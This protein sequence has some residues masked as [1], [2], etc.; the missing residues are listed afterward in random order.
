M[1]DVVIFVVYLAMAFPLPHVLRG[2][3]GDWVWREDW[4][5]PF[6]GVDWQFMS[7]TP[8]IV[9]GHRWFL[10]MIL[11]SRV[12]LR[13][14]GK[15]GAPGWLQTAFWFGVVGVCPVEQ[16]GDP[17]EHEEL[18]MP[19]RW[20]L[21][22]VFGAG[23]EDCGQCPIYTHWIMWFSAF[24]VASFH[25]LRRFMAVVGRRLPKGPVWSVVALG[26]SF[27]IGLTVAAFHYPWSHYRRNP[28]WAACEVITTTLQPML[29]ALGMTFVPVDMSMCGTRA[30]GCYIIHF[31]F[32]DRCTVAIVGAVTALAWDRTGLLILLAIVAY[33]LVWLLLIGPLWLALLQLVCT[34]TA[35]VGRA[36]FAWLSS[37]SSKAAR[38]SA[39]EDDSQSDGSERAESGSDSTSLL[40]K[41]T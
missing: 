25:Y 11:Q 30:I 4:Y 7:C 32:S 14:G 40:A 21:M 17:C 5:G 3:F 18:W 29:L 36:G 9:S 27:C 39:A 41:V 28:L 22:W 16:A 37:V 8:W 15:L 23:G 10:Y 13:I 34:V 2:I 38:G 35:S 12:M 31:F 19:L 33:S 24:Y 1:R 26:C 6:G 20:T